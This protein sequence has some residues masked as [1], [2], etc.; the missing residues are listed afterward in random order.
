MASENTVYSALI[1]DGEWEWRYVRLEEAVPEDMLEA[2]REDPESFRKPPLQ[3]Q[4]SHNIVFHD[5][6]D[7]KTLIFRRP[8]AA[9]DRHSGRVD[10][11][12]AAALAKAKQRMESGDMGAMFPIYT[13]YKT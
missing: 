6:F 2:L 12:K 13:R 10:K 9:S 7:N 4:M 8:V 5:L 1:N 11:S 3:L